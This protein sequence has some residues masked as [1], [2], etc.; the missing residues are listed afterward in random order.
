MAWHARILFTPCQAP[1]DKLPSYW[2]HLTREKN[3]QPYSPL[4][5]RISGWDGELQL[6]M[7]QWFVESASTDQVVERWISGWN[8]QFLMPQRF[9]KCRHC[10]NG[11]TLE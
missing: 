9:G 6:L 4:D 2:E 1:E 8:S 7:L 5:Q 3:Q 10:S 11:L